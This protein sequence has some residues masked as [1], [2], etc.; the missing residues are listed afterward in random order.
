MDESVLNTLTSKRFRQYLLDKFFLRVVISLPRNTF[1]KAQG[2]VK[3]S[4]LYLQKKADPTERQP[5]VF[6][7]ICGNVGHSDSGK[8]RPLLNELPGILDAFQFYEEHG[9]LKKNSSSTI[10]KVGDLITGNDTLRLDAH[11]F[12]PRYFATMNNLDQVAATRGWSL[13]PLSTLL[14][15]KIAGGATPRGASYPDE[16]PKFIRVQN[17]RPYRLTWSEEDPCIDIRTHTVLLKRSQLSEG[18]LV[19]TITGTYG[20][21]AVVPPKF[22]LANINQH[23]VKIQV[24]DE[25]LP[26]YLCVFLNSDLCRPQFD[27]AVTGSS[28]LALDYPAVRRIRI[29]FPQKK[30]EQRRIADQVIMKLQEAS[31]LTEQAEAV[32]KALPKVPFEDLG[33]R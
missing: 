25:I 26:E 6:M 1:V 23:S 21:A 19:L 16:G 12:D 32:T 28:R 31:N 22:G 8:E 33:I 15:A 5:E 18:D 30:K 29:L 14:R 27:R 17:V 4:I 10:F 9:K 2:S 3:T 7:A 24:N 13:K 20:I 11:F